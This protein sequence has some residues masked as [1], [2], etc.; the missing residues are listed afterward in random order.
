MIERDRQLENHYRDEMEQEL[1]NQR[2]AE[3]EDRNNEELEYLYGNQAFG[4]IQKLFG[5]EDEGEVLT[6]EEREELEL[7]QSQYPD[8]YDIAD[9]DRG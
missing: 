4:R 1:E 8:K 5:K 3:R 6:D 7:L 2:L 9:K